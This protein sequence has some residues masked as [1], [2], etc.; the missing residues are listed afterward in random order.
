MDDDRRKKDVKAAK[1]SRSGGGLD[2]TWEGKAKVRGSTMMIEEQKEYQNRDSTPPL[3]DG[4]FATKIKRGRRRRMNQ[5]GDAPE[6][7]L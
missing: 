5:K 7:Q 2:R 6:I 3:C 4:R 1:K